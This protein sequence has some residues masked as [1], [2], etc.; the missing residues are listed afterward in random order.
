VVAN[1]RKRMSVSKRVAQK[2][3]KERFNTKKLNDVEVM[4][5]N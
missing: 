5:V 4:E 2:F 1:L 3:H